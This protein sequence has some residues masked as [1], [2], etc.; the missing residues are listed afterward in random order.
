MT[1]GELLTK[2]VEELGNQSEAARQL[3]VSRQTLIA[4]TR[5]QNPDLTEYSRIAKFAGEPEG[6]VFAVMLSDR[7]ITTAIFEELAD[8][9][10]GVYLS[11]DLLPAA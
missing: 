1:I 7:G 2:K 6:Y 4:W 10:M 9:A 11:S 8:Y 3:G 5:G